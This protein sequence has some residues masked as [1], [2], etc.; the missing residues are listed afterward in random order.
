M[1]DEDWRPIQGF[2]GVYEI[3]SLGRV[4]RVKGACGTRPGR[5]LKHLTNW[6]Y[7]SVALHKGGLRKQVAIHRLVA[8][9]FIPNS[10][11]LPQ[12]N[13]IDGDKSNYSINNLEWVTCGENHAHAYRT[14]L[15]SNLGNPNFGRNGA[16]NG[17]AKITNAIAEE[18]RGLR[19]TMSQS[20]IGQIYGIGQ[21]QVSAILSNRTWN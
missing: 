3:S 20:A 5:T 17:R 18:I 12:V 16:K 21:S 1:N 19:G 6:A 9:A 10:N 8:I 7:P 15:R 4:Q 2:E 13:H 11:N 14:G